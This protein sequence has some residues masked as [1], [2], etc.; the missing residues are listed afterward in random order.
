MKAAMLYGANNVKVTEIPVPEINE[1]ELLVKVQAASLCG[2]DIRMI[3]NGYRNVDAEHPLLLGH[4]FSGVIE[5]AGA[6]VEGYIAGSRVAI[7][8]NWGCGVCDHCVS[9]STHLCEAYQAFGINRPGGFAEYV[10]IPEKVIKQGNIAILSNDISFEA[11]AL[12]EPF[13]CVLN[14]QELMDIQCGDVVLV[15]GAGPI[16]ILHAMLAGISG[17][18]RV[19]MN[20]LSKERLELAKTM[21]EGLI[22]I[23]GNLQEEVMKLTDNR[24]VDVSIIAAP[25]PAAQEQSLNYMAMN[26]KV[27]FFGGLPKDREKVSLNSNTIH[28]KQ[29][30]IMGSARANTRQFR[31]CIKLVEGGKIPIERLIS[32]RFPIDDFPKAVQ[33]A[34]NA[35]EMKNVIVFE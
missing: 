2:S 21:V 5:K 9:G 23:H 10:V 32:N 28:Y 12:I 26:G 8:P 18:S 29:L 35:A 22:T 13:S 34:M 6:K 17:A 11:G 16:G 3:K 33:A 15:V 20:D 7:A 24:G 27:L 31:T 25:A 4:E 14:G 19:F 1:N 30:R